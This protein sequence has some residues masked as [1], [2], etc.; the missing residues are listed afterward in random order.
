MGV[1]PQPLAGPIEVLV[2]LQASGQRFRIVTQL[3]AERCIAGNL[4]LPGRKRLFPR[5]VAGEQAGE[6]PRVGG[7]HFAA[8]RKFFNG[9]HR[10]ERGR[11]SGIRGSGVL[12]RSTRSQI[13]H[14]TQW[15][16][17]GFAAMGS[18]M[19]L[20]LQFIHKRSGFSGTR[21]GHR[22]RARS[23]SKQLWATGQLPTDNCPG[24]SPP[25]PTG[26]GSPAQA[27]AA[28]STVR[29]TKTEQISL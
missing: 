22:D 11:G 29:L 7:G 5:L 17:C 14:K 13:R 25:Y 15:H 21:L 12:R 26:F 19:F 2:E 4:F 18:R 23:P 3:V 8:R 24:R 1:S 6:V 27:L 20:T 16:A 10:E 9:G 28:I